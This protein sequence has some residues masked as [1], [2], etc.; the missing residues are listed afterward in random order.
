MRY[1]AS[2]SNAWLYGCLL[3]LLI[4]LPADLPAQKHPPADLTEMSLEELLNIEVTTAGKKEQTLAQ[5][6][7]AV[8]VITQ[9]EIRRSGATRLPELL[10]LVPGVQV[11]QINANTWAI[12]I[13][14]FNYRY[15]N[16]LLVMVDGRIVYTPLFSGVYW[17]MQNLVLEDIE[18][19]EVIRGPGG[20]LWGANA[21]NGIINVITKP[22]QDTQGALVSATAG[23]QNQAMMQARY[24][25]QNRQKQFSY[26]LYSKY[27]REGQSPALD[28]TQS[29]YDAWS[30]LVGGFRSEWQAA[31]RDLLIFSGE[32][33][34]AS[35]QQAYFAPL[36][37]PP[38]SQNL[39]L[40]LKATEGNLML[41][42]Q[43]QF[44]GGSLSSLQGY[45]DHVDRF[46]FPLG[47]Q[48]HM[49]DISFQHQ[50]RLHERH[51]VVVG[52]EFRLH[53]ENVRNSDILSF[54]TR[55]DVQ[56]IFSGFVQDDI[57]LYP[58]HVWLL[59]GSKFESNPYTGL[60][61]QPSARLRW[62]PLASHS[63]WAAVSRAVRTPSRYEE[64]GQVKP[65]ALPGPPGLPI[66]LTLSGSQQL[67]SEKLLAYEFGY[68]TQPTAS[69]SLDFAFFYNVY[70]DIIGMQ[71][72]QPFLEL[73]PAPP[74]LI[75]PNVFANNL[76]ARTKGIEMAATYKPRSWWKFSTGYSWLQIRQKASSGST[77]LMVPGDVP[78]HQFDFRSYCSLPL[79]LEFDNGIFYAS[80][81]TAQRIPAYVRW[82]SR[83]GWRPTQHLE[84]SLALQN[85][86]DP[87]H[88]EFVQ[89]YDIQGPAQVGR[90]VQGGITW[91]F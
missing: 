13:R 66:L 25:G 21:V 78:K 70:K 33:Y 5:V 68:R 47:W 59:L 79:N 73:T 60:E 41:N 34:R 15:S 90:R 81:L 9:E 87:H 77:S 83:W 42:W 4:L 76:N 84:F 50:L 29:A 36:L 74:H 44:A 37:Q 6:P 10:R 17:D 35:E 1:H 23:S 71:P 39:T 52:T 7:A 56:N 16:K 89:V 11:A 40:P 32:V 31:P 18:R 53:Q 20:T 62:Q 85:L 8:Y 72:G 27:F 30:D 14:G 38:F 55:A 45:Y 64:E 24:G 54:G 2:F 48:Q 26:R 28:S 67:V 80:S 19:I 43:H 46:F 49:F 12:S 51:E 82:D 63:F 22:A 57:T 75:A 88:P 69:V 91:Q 3:C 65:L 86:L 61:V 58:T